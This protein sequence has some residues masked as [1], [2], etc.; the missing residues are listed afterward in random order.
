M[1]CHCVSAN[2]PAV[3]GDKGGHRGGGWRYSHSN[4][5]VPLLATFACLREPCI[6]VLSSGQYNS[7]LSAQSQP[8]R[9]S[10]YSR[11]HAGAAPIIFSL[12]S[13]I[14]PP[15]RRVIVSTVV[16]FS[17]GAGSLLGQT[18]AG[19]SGLE[20]RLPFA[21]IGIPSVLV[22]TIMLLTTKDPQRGGAEPVLKE[23]FADET[24]EYDQRLTWTK[25]KHVMRVPTNFLVIGQVSASVVLLM[26][27]CKQNHSQPGQVS[28][29]CILSTCAFLASEVGLYRNEVTCGGIHRLC[30]R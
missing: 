19:V 10:W 13:D 9:C 5:T 29:L 26:R 17:T 15:D 8:A 7:S 25:F 14:Y 4:R 20:W 12:L 11:L 6:H 16:L 22:A 27:H 21:I 1:H 18:L 3:V 23:A 28:T 2:V 24:F 30:N